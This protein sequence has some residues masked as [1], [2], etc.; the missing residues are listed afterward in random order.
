ML[1]SR[2]AADYGREGKAS[3]TTEAQRVS[4]LPDQLLSAEFQQKS[5]INF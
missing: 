2:D 3:S 4:L 1:Q 5:K